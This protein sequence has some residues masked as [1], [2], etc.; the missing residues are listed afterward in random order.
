MCAGGLSH[1]GNDAEWQGDV[2]RG[3]VPV[4]VRACEIQRDNESCDTR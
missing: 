1:E 4:G 3:T 2:L